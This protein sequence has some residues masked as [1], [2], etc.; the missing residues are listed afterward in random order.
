MTLDPGSAEHLTDSGI[1]FETVADDAGCCVILKRLNLPAGYDSEVADVLIRL[2]AG[3]PDTAPDMF[4]VD[5]ALNLKGGGR[6]PGTE[7]HERHLDRVW[8]RW[9]RHIGGH[10]RPGIDTIRSYVAYIRRCLEEPV[11]VAA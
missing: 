11:R 3:F 9:S 4:W 1:D 5:P 8:Q 10:W 2:P 6:P 7:H